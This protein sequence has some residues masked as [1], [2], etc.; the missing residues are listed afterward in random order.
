M[1]TQSRGRSNIALKTASAVQSRTGIVRP[2]NGTSAD[3]RLDVIVE[4]QHAQEQVDGV[5]PQRSLTWPSRSSLL[6]VHAAEL[7]ALGQRREDVPRALGPDEHVDVNVSGTTR[8]ERAVA[9]RD[10]ASD[11]VRDGRASRPS[12]IA[13]S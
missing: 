12:W 10:R 3:V 1:S 6:E 4:R 11:R 8:F 7:D 9:E 5:M 2:S 13:S